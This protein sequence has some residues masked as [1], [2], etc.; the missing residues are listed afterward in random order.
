PSPEEEVP[1]VATPGETNIPPKDL[2]FTLENQGWGNPVAIAGT[3][4]DRNGFSDIQ[5]IELSVHRPGEAWRAIASVT[6]FTPDPTDDTTANFTYDWTEQLGAGN[7]KI[8][9][10]AYDRAGKTSNVVIEQLTL[11][12]TTTETPNPSP[13]GPPIDR[14]PPQNPHRISPIPPISPIS[15]TLPTL[16][17]S[18]PSDLRFS[19]FPLYTTGEI[20]SFEG[21]KVYD[22]DGIEDLSS[23]E[24]SIR[25]IGEDWVYAGE[26]TEFTQDAEGYGR[27]GFTYHL[28]NLT[29]GSYELRSVAYDRQGA[30]SN[31]ATENFVIITD[32]GGEGLSDE[33]KLDIA[34]AANLAR[35]TP[36]ELANTQKWVVW[37]TPGQSAD[38]LAASVNAVNLGETGQIPNTYL[39]EFGDKP[40]PQTTPES[41]ANLLTELDGVEFAYPE[42]PV[43]LK[44]MNP[45]G[46]KGGQFPQ[47]H[48]EDAVNPNNPSSVTSAWN[49]INSQTDLPVLGRNVV[50]GFVDDGVDYTHPD[51][52]PR[53]NPNLSFDFSDLDDDPFPRSQQKFEE[54]VFKPTIDG[55]RVLLAIPVNL[56]GLVTDINFNLE[57]KGNKPLSLDEATFRLFSP[58]NTETDPFDWYSFSGHWWR[59][60]GWD[61]SRG[62]KHT[63]L[64]MNT[65]NKSV[66][67]ALDNQFDGIYAG[68]YWQLEISVDAYHPN[69]AKFLQDITNQIKSWSLDIQAINPH[70][71]L[72]TGTGVADGMRL[73]GV[74][75][76]AD[77]AAIRLIGNIDPVNYSYD[78][79]GYLI[80]DAL[81]DAK[82]PGDALNRNNGIAIFNNSWGP[83]YMRQ[84]P[85]ATAAL[86]SG[87]KS[88]RNGLG[89]S[90]VFSVGNDGAE[91]GHVNYNNLAKSRSVI[92]VGAISR[93]GILS[94]YSTQAP[95]VVAYSDSGK[96][97]N[98][99]I[100]TTA[101]TLRNRMVT[102]FGGTSASAPFVSG[103]I[104]LMLEV[105][106]D[107]TSRDI[108]HILAKTAYKT[109]PTHP[110]WQ[111]NGGGHHINR[112]YGFGA[113][114]PVA[115]VMAA[116]DW[117]LVGE[118]VKVT[119]EKEL[120]NVL[121]QIR[122][123]QKLT[124]AIAIDQDITVEH[125][126]VLVNINHPDWK[127][128]T[129]TLKSPDG[130]ESR[131][132]NSIPDDPYGIGKTYEVHPGSNHWTFT[133]VRHWG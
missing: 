2:R 9:A 83:Q 129:L 49:I 44:L 52:L 121:S 109:D 81:Y 117:T 19:L 88:G 36:E 70:G 92:S 3:V 42:V 35:Y 98:N 112:Y 48:L 10:V 107:L 118:Q 105:N 75:P 24:F 113:V 124:D 108:Q 31:I 7:Y 114:D 64:S 14:I 6:H 115:A 96:P 27:F 46:K 53:Y 79:Q 95:F 51:L 12:D 5:R 94:D 38:Q 62:T 120:K 20:L 84:L 132:M 82:N 97:D 116:Q 122:D 76:E 85:L 22:S 30:T 91:I 80:A 34:G 21:G 50:I 87:F 33:L 66:N 32:P 111:Q 93:D 18:Q 99:G 110:D 16:P 11:V 39:W 128:L 72:V 54:N 73:S 17:N 123:N 68:G 43:P 29:P 71:T 4:R 58:I 119:G 63:N 61:E 90:Y 103:A 45:G 26:V 130:T 47:W 74:A 126:E 40:K 23:I 65:V 89:N 125:A 127:D 57:F 131:L 67:I 59:Y 101:T 104:A 55:N 133:S 13:P 8:K 100:T 1:A 77:F 28:N 25:K 41:I 37:V 102:D 15:P 78:S 106:P 60:P 86:A 56:T 69:P